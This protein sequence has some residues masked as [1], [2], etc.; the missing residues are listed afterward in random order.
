MVERRIS[1]AEVEA[2]LANPDLTYHD[3]K[4]NPNFVR[5]LAGRPIRVVVARDRNPT[6]GIRRS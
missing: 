3:K 2:V 1:E 4:G 5:R 6:I